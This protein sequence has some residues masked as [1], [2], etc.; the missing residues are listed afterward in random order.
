M[1][2]TKPVERA[3]VYVSGLG[4]FELFLN[5]AKVGDN[6]LDPAWSDYDRQVCYQTFDISEELQPGGN[7]FRGDARQRP[8]QLPRERYFKALISFGYPKDD[9]QG[10]DRVC[11]RTHETI[12]SDR[13]WR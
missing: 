4:Q 12:V 3:T 5:G 6:F 9:L 8:L 11:R 2:V 13:A 10:R 7:V 1:K